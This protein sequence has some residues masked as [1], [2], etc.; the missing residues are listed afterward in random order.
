VIQE[1]EITVEKCAHR[2]ALSLGLKKHGHN[3]SA[4][5]RGSRLF[6]AKPEQQLLFVC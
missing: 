5:N 4:P 1:G 2:G 3:N 6:G